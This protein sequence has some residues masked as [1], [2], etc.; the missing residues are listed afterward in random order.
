MLSSQGS[1]HRSRAGSESPAPCRNAAVI[2]GSSAFNLDAPRELNG[3]QRG[4]TC[5]LED[6]AASV[7]RGL[8]RGWLVLSAR[9]E[10]E[11][12][13]DVIS[14]VLEVGVERLVVVPLLPQFSRRTTGSL[15]DTLYRC[16]S[17]V[18]P[19]LHVE[20]R[21]SWFDDTEYVSSLADLVRNAVE[22][23]EADASKS[24]V[25]LI[26]GSTIDDDDAYHGHLA[27]TARL[28][29][30]ELGWHE[31]RVAVVDAALQGT[32]G[33][34]PAIAAQSSD[35]Q[36]LIVLSAGLTSH[37]TDLHLRLAQ[38]LPADRFTLHMCDE[39]RGREK[40]AK[41]LGML[42]RRGRHAASPERCIKR[43][44]QAPCQRDLVAD[45]FSVGVSIPGAAP[46]IDD[47]QAGPCSNERFLQIKRP[48]LEALQLLR[49]LRAEFGLPE[50]W[51]FNTCHRFEFY[52]WFPSG[53]DAAARATLIEK[54]SAVIGRGDAGG[55]RVLQGERARSHLIRTAAGLNSG[56]LGD[57]DVAE[58]LETGL[59]AAEYAGTAGA[60]SG[61]LVKNV[62]E[63]VGRLR[64]QT[65]WGRFTHRYTEI[66]MLQLPQD[67]QSRLSQ[68][69][70]TVVGG[71]TTAAS[72]IEVL[73]ER[74]GVDP[75]RITVIYRGNR[76]GPLMNR[77]LASVG[78]ERLRRVEDYHHPSVLASVADADVAFL[79]GDHREAVLT[80]SDVATMRGDGRNRLDVVDFNTFGSIRETGNL[81]LRLFDAASIAASITA[82]NHRTWSRPEFLAA[83]DQAEGWISHESGVTARPAQTLA[84]AE[85]RA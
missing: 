56:L 45:L 84:L 78:P 35:P 30:A 29:A 4:L 18:T 2:V 36:E 38:H 10:A 65:A 13:L 50:C 69:K 6:L 12:L 62:I 48:H 27:Q 20:V 21:S 83:L 42:I 57:A 80:G 63:A 23:A 85:S 7:Q 39:S 24:R 17:T 55:V 72:L 49:D 15:L 5:D 81:A 54:L 3:R 74:Y 28:L 71:S 68:G 32:P 66:A 41:T 8:P 34:A 61:A 14:H 31:N 77:F 9:P 46:S 70:I 33:W 59:R 53:A 26:P 19:D 67:V 64:T 60:R 79:A 43:V 40:L 37:T 1:S 58:Q 22:R 73:R 75:D 44:E 76:S 51:L 52:A 11:E 25:M 82:F 16:L 47:L